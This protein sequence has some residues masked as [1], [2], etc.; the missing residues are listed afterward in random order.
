MKIAITGT[1]TGVGSALVT[2]L[3][4]H[5]VISIDRS[6]LDLSVVDHVKQFTMPIVDILI[7]CAGTGR[8]G[9]TTF[10]NHDPDCVVEILNTNLVSAVLLSQKALQQNPNCKIVNITST[11]NRHY[12][13]NDLAYSLSKLGLA[14]FSDMLRTEYP[15][16]S[17][18]EVRLGLTK[19]N[20][21][22]NRYTGFED[23]YVDIY[24]K[25]HLTTDVV[26]KRICSVLFD[27]SIKFI[28]IAP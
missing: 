23:R 19:T 11:N 6:N 1:T 20:F 18:L 26:A 12:W 28:E 3:Q 4:S 15:T 24:N 10:T 5:E 2:E 22:K 14:N 16:T 21:N 7:N 17:I 13:G 27:D 9:K 8:G 25:A